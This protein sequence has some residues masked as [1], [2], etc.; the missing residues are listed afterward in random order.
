MQVKEEPYHGILR[1]WAH[2]NGE[3]QVFRSFRQGTWDRCIAPT[4]FVEQKHPSL[5]A[6]GKRYQKLQPDFH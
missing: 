5:E 6:K 3:A 1:V 4:G 2:F